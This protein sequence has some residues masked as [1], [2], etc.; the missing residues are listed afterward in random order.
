MSIRADRTSLAIPVVFAADGLVREQ[1]MNTSAIAPKCLLAVG[2]AFLSIVAM[3]CGTVAVATGSPGSAAGTPANCGAPGSLGRGVTSGDPNFTLA[4]PSGTE[5]TMYPGQTVTLPVSVMS[6]NGGAG[7]VTLQVSGLPSGVTAAPVKVPIGRTANLIF[8][9]SLSAATECFTGASP[10]YIA[11]STLNLNG[12]GTGGSQAFGVDLDVNLSNPAFKPVSTDLPTLDIE[13]AGN[14]EVTSEDDY[15]NATMTLIDPRKPDDGFSGSMTIK[16]HGNSTWGMPKKPYRIKLPSKSKLLNMP[17][18]KNWV[19]LANYDDKT[20]LRDA[21]ASKVSNIT[22]APWAPRSAFV[23]LTLNGEYEGTYQLIENVDVN[24]SRVAIADSDAST[25]P[26]QEGYLLEIDAHEGAS[27]HW[28][29]PHGLDISSD[30][31]DPPTAD[32]EAYITPLVN[33]AEAGF[34]TTTAPDAN[35]GWRSKWDQDSVVDWFIT[36]ELMG[37]QDADAYSSDYFYK[38]A[39]SALFHMGPIWDFDI[40]S[41]NDNYGSIQDPT[42]PWVKTQHPWFVGLFQNDPTFTTAV[43]ARWTAIRP[44]VDSLSSFIDANAETL[45]QASQNN[46]ARWP[47]LYQKVW[48][49]PEAAGSYSGEINYLKDWLSKRIAY[50][51]SEYLSE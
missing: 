51:D 47:T 17:S 16:G 37:N 33:T 46:Y 32:Q 36:N 13:T 14:V 45:Q 2:S 3:G 18:E 35:A 20:M 15:T 49:N 42:V 26:T 34:F 11:T 44:Q 40:S 22:G 31:P 27:Y 41:G 48:P 10:Y 8:T 7:I 4:V 43:K 12:S 23:E 1:T 6:K 28:A 50:M 38:D 25:D 9:S 39:N 21:L 24:G 29:T 5:F 19:L 30:D